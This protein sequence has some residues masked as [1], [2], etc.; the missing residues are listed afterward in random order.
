[1]RILI[2]GLLLSLGLLQL[3]FTGCAEL[4]YHGPNDT[5][6]RETRTLLSGI[7]EKCRDNLKNELLAQKECFPR[8]SNKRILIRVTEISTQFGLSIPRECRSN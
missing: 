6:F 8:L 5:E 7:R 2:R 1:M 4:D 3:I